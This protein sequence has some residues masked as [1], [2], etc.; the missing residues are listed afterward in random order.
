MGT[1]V[2][3]QKWIDAF[4]ESHSHRWLMR[5]RLMFKNMA[6]F[7]L[8]KDRSLNVVDVGAGTG[9]FVRTLHEKGYTNGRG[10]EYDPRLIP[11]DLKEFVD[12]G[13]ATALP[14]EDA[15]IDVI[16]FFNVLHHLLDVDQYRATME[17]VHRCLKPGG[18]LVM[19]EPD[20]LWFYRLTMVGAWVLSPVMKVAGVIFRE[21][22]DE[23][24]LIAYF[25]ANNNVF[26]DFS[27]QNGYKVIRDRR[28]MHQ[29]VHVATKPMAADGK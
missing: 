24:E 18:T 17:E 3:T 21:I 4:Q 16:C 25:F 9:D 6:F 28:L 1:E 27:S 11:D 29:W 13:S 22:Y 19:Q 14:Y 23:R 8:I 2:N 26:K 5:M 10:L 12:Q 15:S 20:K 7:D